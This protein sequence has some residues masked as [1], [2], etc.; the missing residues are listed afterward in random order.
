MSST[1]P[2]A[3]EP[4]SK[5]SEKEKPGEATQKPDQHESPA[6]EAKQKGEKRKAEPG[7]ATSAQRRKKSSVGTNT[8]FYKG[9]QSPFSMSTIV[10]VFV[11]VCT[12]SKFN[13]VQM[14]LV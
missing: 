1:D 7:K 2:V 3:P 5:P 4:G 6:K 8:H 13:F 14:H 9:L 11:D 10:I 12:L